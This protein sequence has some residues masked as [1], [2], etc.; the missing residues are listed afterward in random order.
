MPQSKMQLLCGTGDLH[1]QCSNAYSVIHTPPPL[2]WNMGIF[3]F[4]V[5]PARIVW[6]R[7]RGLKGG[8]DEGG[9]G[10]GGE[11]SGAVGWGGMEEGGV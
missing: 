9:G 5:L 7:E 1:V 6:S 11:E 8:G 3:F 4:L 10:W 2:T